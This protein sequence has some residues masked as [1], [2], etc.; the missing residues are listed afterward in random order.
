M[1]MTPL[2]TSNTI[3]IPVL[4]Y[5]QVDQPPAKGAPYRSLVVAPQDFARQM[6]FLS[7]LGYRGLSMGDLMPYLRGEKVGKVVG[8]TLDD[9]YL[10]NLQNAAPVLKRH[11]FTATCYVVSQRVGQTNDW[12]AGKG[13]ASAALMDAA[14]IREWHGLGLEVGAHTRTHCHLLELDAAQSMHEIAD[15]KRELEALIQAPVLHFCYPY[16]D[17]AEAH[18]EQVKGAGFASATTTQRGRCQRGENVFQL[19]RVPVLRSTTRLQLLF[20][21]ATRYEDK[22]RA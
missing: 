1:T 15:C 19:P 16:G 9:G 22:R 20:K 14:A 7:L 2:L 11:G 3:P 13:I 10:N 4:T 21:L 5:H 18:A 12:D 6:Q 17:F 8:I